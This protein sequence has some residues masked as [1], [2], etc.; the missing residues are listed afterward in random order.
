MLV[1]DGSMKESSR[2]TPWRAALKGKYWTK[3]NY[4][5]KTVTSKGL[6]CLQHRKPSSDSGSQLQS[7]GLLQVAEQVSRRQA[8]DSFQFGLWIQG[9]SKRKN[10]E[11]GVN[12]HLVT[13]LSCF[14]I[15][16]LGVRMSLVYDSL[17]RWSTAPGI[18]ELILPWRNNP[19][20]HVNDDIY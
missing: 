10:K 13:F 6:G 1:W 17:T 11:V 12:H 15:I 14:L 2:L 20:L 9:F 7:R 3:E 5:Y 4:L 19:S 18:Q 16:V 8:S